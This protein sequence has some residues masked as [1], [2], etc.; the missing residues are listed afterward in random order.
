M[1]E[2]NRREKLVCKCVPKNKTKKVTFRK[3]LTD[4]KIIPS[5]THKRSNTK[6]KTP[7]LSKRVTRSMK[8][9]KRK[10]CPNGTR[11]NSKTGKCEKK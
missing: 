4:V 2:C 11:K 8:V 1:L 10:R 5:R 6:K 7:V 9:K 3:K